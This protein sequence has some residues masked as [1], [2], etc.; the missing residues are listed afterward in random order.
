MRR[1]FTL[2]LV[3]AVCVGAA[4]VSAASSTT[5]RARVTVIGDS[6][7]TAMALESDARLVL[8]RGIDLDLQVAP[9]RRLVGESCPYEGKRPPTL[10]ELLPSLRLGP[11][12]VV[13]TGYNDYEST[14][15]S[16]I[17]TTLT[18]L[19]D[20]GVTSVLWLTLRAERQSYLNMNDLIREAST[21]H[22]DLTVV[23]WNLYSRSHPD[24]FQA[25]GLHL[26][27]DG[28]IAMATLVHGKLDDLGLVAMP[29]RRPLAIATTRLPAG[30]VR[31][32]YT[33]RLRTTGGTV[34]V[35]WVLVRGAIPA[36]LALKPRGVLSG[37][38]R[39]AGKR[40]LL[41]RATDLAGRSV[42]RRFTITIT[43]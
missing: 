16:T 42:A 33:I 3:A 6:I 9:C 32:R 4:T 10:I 38:P 15:A 12:V 7:A 36:G 1:A 34:P 14:F 28:A 19:R 23:D 29:T 18:A 5:P 31:G 41:L 21:R 11:T 37:T 30:H 13:A 40:S 2:I 22:S 35:R 8:E 17:E 24:W 25:D 27:R 20:A 39:M 43:P 26:R